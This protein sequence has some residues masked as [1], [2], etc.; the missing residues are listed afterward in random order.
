M[1][2]IGSTEGSG[3]SAKKSLGWIALTLL[4]LAT[5]VFVIV[6][7]G[8]TQS[9]GQLRRV[10]FLRADTSSIHDA[11]PTSYWTLWNV[12]GGPEGDWPVWS[13]CRDMKAGFRFDPQSNFGFAKGVPKKFV[14]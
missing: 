14:G 4:V 2:Q 13:S 8:G 5:L 10:W 12:C 11:S 6:F 1:R 3:R 9:K 7:F